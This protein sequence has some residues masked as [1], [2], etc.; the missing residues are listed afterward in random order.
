MQGAIKASGLMLVVALIVMVLMDVQA[1]TIGKLELF[2]NV[3]LTQRSIM[4]SSLNVGDL[5]VNNE[6][7]M[8]EVYVNQTWFSHFERLR[9]SSVSYQ[10]GQLHTLNMPPAIGVFIKSHIRTKLLKGDFEDVF[11]SVILVERS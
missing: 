10:L 4:E 1:V 6:L 8:N 2:S 11:S 7:S 3:R 5:I 9:N